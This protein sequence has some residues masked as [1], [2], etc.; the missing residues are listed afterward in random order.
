MR[1]TSPPLFS[2]LRRWNPMSPP[3]W[4]WDRAGRLIDDGRYVSRRRDDTE[5]G[6]AV[7]FIRAWDRCETDRDFARLARREPELYAAHAIYQDNRDLRM[8]LEARLLARQTPEQVAQR[9]GVSAAV[10]HTY[11]SVFF[12]IADR[13]DARDWICWFA[14][15]VRSLDG[16]REKAL[17]AVVRLC[18]YFGGPLVLEAVLKEVPRVPDLFAEP[19]DLA[20]I[21]GQIAARVRMFL[22]VML[23]PVNKTTLSDLLRL[24]QAGA[25]SAPLMSYLPVFG[26]VLRDLATDLPD[27]LLEIV[28]KDQ[29]GCRGGADAEVPVSQT[30]QVA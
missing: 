29:P 13:L 10:V 28:A 3:D 27:E 23:L 6:R 9:V 25:Q 7:Y 4:R 30:R 16:P 2:E 17:P 5:T 14:I 24:R 22:A 19:P 15:G 21:D 1:W 12:D 11:T 20:T 8:V 18:G 26:G